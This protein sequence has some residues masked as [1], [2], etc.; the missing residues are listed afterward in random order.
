VK[1]FVSSNKT[2]TVICKSDSSEVG[3]S[4]KVVYKTS[5]AATK[6]DLVLNQFM[7]GRCGEIDSPTTVESKSLKLNGTCGGG[8]LFEY[9]HDILRHC[10]NFCEIKV[11]DNSKRGSSAGDLIGPDGR[12]RVD[13]NKAPE[14]LKA[15][16]AAAAAATASLVASEI[17]PTKPPL[18]LGPIVG[19][20]TSQSAIIMV[21][22]GNPGERAKR[23]LHP[24]LN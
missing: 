5:N 9:E 8:G 24:L 17:Y 20:V 7:V 15:T 2:V 12:V 1:K 22:V 23:R 3:M 4:T 21:E 14:S 10:Q 16:A 6:T 19:K 13:E 18:L 11:G